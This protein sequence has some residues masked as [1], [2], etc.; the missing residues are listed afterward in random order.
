MK[1]RP[2]TVYLAMTVAMLFWG[3]SFIL[4]EMIF[5]KNYPPMTVILSRL[6]ISSAFLWFLNLFLK[7]LQKIDKK[8]LKWFLFLAFLQPFVYFIGENYG[9]IYTTPTVTSIV[10]ATIPLF[11]PIAAFYFFRERISMINIIGIIISVLGIFLV[12]LKEDNSLD[13]QS[14][15][16]IFLGIAVFSAVAYSIVLLKLSDKYN[17]FSIIAHQNSIGILYFIPCIFIFD[18]DVLAEVGFQADTLLP[19]F[20]LAIFASSFAFI[21]FTYGV[22]KIGVTK[23][24]AFANIIPAFTVTFDYLIFDRHLTK[25]NIIGVVIVIAGLS[26]AQLNQK[27]IFAITKTFFIKL[28]KGYIRKNKNMVNNI[29]KRNRA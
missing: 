17:V 23:A 16:F 15:G 3:G 7:R 2:L 24:N 1:D 4:T 20:L 13:G 27:A 28:K 29:K 8:D 14:E 19:L 26:L 25:L 6:L 22:K 9:L 5:E 21:L 12:I 11:S 18:L 10:I